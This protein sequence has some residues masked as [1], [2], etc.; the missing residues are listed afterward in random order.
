MG[1]QDLLSLGRSEGV[2]LLAADRAIVG[3]AQRKRIG[4]AVNG[5]GSFGIQGGVGIA[6][7]ELLGMH[8]V[9]IADRGQFV[10]DRAVIEVGE[11]PC[12]V[13]DVRDGERVQIIQ[14]IGAVYTPE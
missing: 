8:A 3:V 5:I 6:C 4:I 13:V 10:K 7:G 9:E 11:L 1:Q 14:H 2:E 12:V